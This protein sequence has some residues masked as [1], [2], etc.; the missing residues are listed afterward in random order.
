M[1]NLLFI[2]NNQFEYFGP[3]YLSAVLKQNGHN[4]KLFVP[5]QE[6][7]IINEIKKNN[8]DAFLVSCMTGHHGKDIGFLKELKLRFSKPIL[9]GGPH[10]TF[11]QDVLKIPE[12][13]Y[14][15]I[16]EGEEF[17][18]DFA[19]KLDS[20][21]RIE[22]IP[23]LGCKKNGKIKINPVRNLI[24]DL[25]K[26]PFADRTLYYDHY[27]ALAQ[28][29][30]KRF[31]ATRGCPYN[32]SFCFNHTLQ[33]IYSGK[34]KYMRYRSPENIIEEINQ[35][36]ALYPT[37]TIRFPDDSLTINKKWLYAFLKIYKKNI[38][39]PFSCLVRA[40]ELDEDIV[41]A[42]KE[43]NCINVFFGIETGNE[44]LRNNILHKS[45]KNEDIIKGA[46]L[47]RKHKI[48][49]GT[50]NMLGLPGETLE[51]AF[52]TIK[53]NQKIKNTL[54]SSTIMQPYP[55]T[56]IVN[57]ALKHGYLDKKPDVDLITGMLSDSLFKIKNINKFIN[58][59]SFFYIA[60]R[61]PFLI[62]LIKLLIKFPPNGFYRF[63]SFISVGR[64]RLKA[65]N[66]TI[67]EGLKTAL[68]FY[69]KL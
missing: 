50:Y 8:P 67:L 25:D 2:Q 69:K 21:G 22:S 43:A 18:V 33:S 44:N 64:V 29:P 51:L 3:M 14:I 57:Y 30:T 19:N 35:V 13:D 59:N 4:C 40:N 62:P 28:Y 12:I 65:Q 26:L 46:H 45:L 16:G 20:K 17:I 9:L 52:E 42:L 23:N 7:N 47:L 63:L 56:E 10:P 60:V 61:F 66:L 39:L 37:R 11:F 48:S 41:T 49:F 53:L 54:P 15:C 5:S 24:K 38:K 27:P 36:K 32:C 58:L 1:A 6:K 55:R 34:G 31:L 68:R